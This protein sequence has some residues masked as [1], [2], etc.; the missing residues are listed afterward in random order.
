MADRNHTTTHPKRAGSS[1]VSPKGK[2]KQKNRSD[3]LHIAPYLAKY[4]SLYLPKTECYL[5]Y[6]SAHLCCD[7]S[8]PFCF[9]QCCQQRRRSKERH[10][11]EKP[12][13]DN[14]GDDGTHTGGTEQPRKR[15][16]SAKTTPAHALKTRISALKKSNSCKN[17]VVSDMQK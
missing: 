16:L 3:T 2:N 14:T 12:N 10:T 4:K 13:I 15:S 8:P 7:S 17:L 11:Q 6:G 9:K 5:S 1:K